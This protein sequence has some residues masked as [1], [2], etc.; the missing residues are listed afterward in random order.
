MRHWLKEL[1]KKLYDKGEI[2]EERITARDIYKR[3]W[4]CRDFEL[5]H[6]WQR[7]IFLTTFL[8]LCFT[9]YGA[10]VLKLCDSACECAYKSAEGVPQNDYHILI[11]HVAGILVAFLGVIL[12]ELWVMMAKGS[13][14]WYEIYEN[15]IQTMENDTPFIQDVVKNEMLSKGLT[16]D[17]LP[18]P[19]NTNDCLLCTEAGMFSSSKINIAIGQVSMVMW[20]LVFVLHLLIFAFSHSIMALFYSH[21]MM[22]PIIM[23]VCMFLLLPWVLHILYDNCKSSYKPKAKKK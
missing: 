4:K 6:L 22:C 16:N 15:A 11:L 23:P 20:I 17:S 2:M 18:L 19:E 5:T 14:A 13:K 7:S 3:L 12:S 9:G 1:V 21:P 8:V 10:I